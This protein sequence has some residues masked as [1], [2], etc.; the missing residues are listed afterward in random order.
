VP[1]VTYRNRPARHCRGQIFQSHYYF[2]SGSLP[3]VGLTYYKQLGY[4][5]KQ[6]T[7]V[8]RGS[9]FLPTDRSFSTTDSLA[10]GINAREAIHGMLQAA[11]DAF[12]RPARLEDVY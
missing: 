8:P 5:P 4:I 6:R 10:K 1:G 7:V 11:V 3:K 2:A 9:R 12:S